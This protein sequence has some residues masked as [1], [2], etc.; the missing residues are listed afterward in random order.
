MFRQPIAP[1]IART[2]ERKKRHKT[3]TRDSTALKCAPATNEISRN[4]C[5]IRHRTYNRRSRRIKILISENPQIGT[6]RQECLVT[7]S[8]AAAPL[9]TF[10]VFAVIF[11][12]AEATGVSIVTNASDSGSGSLRA[13][14]SGSDSTI[15]FDPVFFSTP[16]TIA[17]LSPLPLIERN[18]A[19]IGPGSDHLTIDGQLR[20][21][22]SALIRIS[23]SFTVRLE[24]FT[25]TGGN[26]A[27]STSNVGGIFNSS[28][29]LTLS[30]V[31]IANNRGNGVF[32]QAGELTSL[33]SSFVGNSRE[34][35][36][37]QVGVATIINS[38]FAQ[39]NGGIFNQEGHLTVLNSTIA[40]NSGHGLVSTFNPEEQRSAGLIIESSLLA[41]NQFSDLAATAITSI[42]YSL[43]E[44]V[45]DSAVTGIANIVGVDPQLASLGDNG[46]PTPTLLPQ[47]GSPAI[48]TGSNPLN[49]LTDQR[50]RPR[51]LGS[52]PDIG[53][54]ETIPEPATLTLAAAPLAM[55]ICLMRRRQN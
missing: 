42:K 34:A 54:V 51:V 16:R 8:I 40:K 15:Q 24:G 33:R 10:L 22:S 5:L 14:M 43:V 30:E 31:S 27:I 32:N 11:A 17:L 49:L 53:A 37:N 1:L 18:L 28:A 19:I 50:G 3:P 44:V 47:P 48:N 29:D 25:L 13:A 55:L 38:T 20:P 35:I 6:T 23:R 36:F 2:G 7:R 9:T 39:N 45:V 52:T 41:D 12:S 26:D 21:N 4:H 46:G